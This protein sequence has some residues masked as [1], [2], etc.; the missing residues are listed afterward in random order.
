MSAP[1][2]TFDPVT[3]TATASRPRVPDQALHNSG[4][5]YTRHSVEAIPRRLRL[6]GAVRWNA[7]KYRVERAALW[8]SDS[9]R[10]SDLSGSVGAVA[11]IT[12][13]FR[14]HFNHANGFRAPSMT[15]LGT[16]GLTGD[17]FEVSAADV[18]GLDAF[19]GSTADNASRST[20]LPVTQIKSERTFNYEAGFRFTALAVHLSATGFVLDLKDAVVKQALILPQGAVGRV[21][22]GGQTVS[23][24]TVNGAV[25]VPLST[26][27]VLVRTNLDH[28]RHYGWEMEADYRAATD[29][30][31]HTNATW[32]RAFDTATGLAPNIEG[33]IPAARGVIAVKYRPQ[34]RPYEIQ[35]STN[36][37]AAQ[38]RFSTLD[39][40]DR[41]TGAT[42]TRATI[43]NY[44]NR[45]AVVHGLVRSGVLIATGETLAQVQDRVLGVGVNSSPLIRRLPGYVLLNLRSTFRIADNQDVHVGVEN[46][47]DRN[48]R[49]VNWG[50]PGI[51]VD[52]N[53]RYNVRF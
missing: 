46:L 4:G 40:A 5:V 22:L 19:V 17:G 9:A 33:G 21:N 52:L 38:S 47:T 51:G 16:L 7:A 14:I 28:T 20:G 30:S 32:V 1:A 12:S 48:Y 34:R 11:T 36:L 39:I 6:T 2:F 45:A 10:S 8:P 26:T 13:A 44:F 49:G 53:I 41:R 29:W 27:P 42:R 3:R 23:Q 15:D 24:Q 25:F 37:V 18:A 43:S 31:L 35:L 50:A